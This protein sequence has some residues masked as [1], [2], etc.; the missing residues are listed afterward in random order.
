MIDIALE[1]DHRFGLVW[2]FLGRS[3]MKA[4]RGLAVG[5]ALALASVTAS[6]QDVYP[7]KPVRLMVPY[8]AGGVSDI[9]G[10]ALAQKMS[11]LLGQPMVVE[12]RGG[13]GGTLGTALIANAPPDGYSIVLSSLTAYAI[14]PHMM[15]TVPYD[16]VKSFTAIGG[17]AV[18]PNILTVN[19]AAPF[20]SLQDIITYAK[21]NPDKLTFGSSGIGSVGHLSGEVLRT[22]TNVSMVH[23][24][25]KSAGLA[26]PDVIAGSV[27]MVFDTLPSAIQHVKS[28]KVKPIAV[29]SD[30]R[31]PLLPEVPTF[32]E[33]GFPEATLH[34]W[35]GLHG[36]AN[37]SPAAVQ[38]LSETLQKALASSDLSERFVGLG[39]EPYPL[40]PQQ[41]AKKT[42]DDYEKLAGVIKAAGIKPE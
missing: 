24:P 25:Y 18:A 21:A 30:K 13:A 15:K 36:P 20:K 4:M 26:Y 28:G 14:A 22:S 16:P 3:A 39:A 37:M 5:F 32:A 23:V 7:S 17:V 19:A 31:S 40:T 27:S 35:I 38:K 29:L 11:E 2:F 1:S 41:F 12:N 33:A 8:A 34:F 6:G 42:S 10:R 9:I